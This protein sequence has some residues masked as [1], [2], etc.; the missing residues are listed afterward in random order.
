[1]NG[2]ITAHLFEGGGNAGVGEKFSVFF[3]IIFVGN[4]NL[5]VALLNQ[6]A[7][8]EIVFGKPEQIVR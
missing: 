6:K 1:M 7:A 4:N 2:Q 3:A 8:V 5:T